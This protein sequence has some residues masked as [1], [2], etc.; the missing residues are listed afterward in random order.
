[1]AKIYDASGNVVK[2]DYLVNTY[3]TNQ[4]AP[5]LA[6][7][8]DGS[9]VVTWSSIAQDAS[10]DAGVYMRHYSASVIKPNRH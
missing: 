2:T 8:A 10:P 7:L 4:Y 1:M 6:A 3:T 9:F 5:K